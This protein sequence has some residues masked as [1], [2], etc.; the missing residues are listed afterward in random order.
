MSSCI[1]TNCCSQEVTS[2]SITSWTGAGILCPYSVCSRCDVILS[3]PPGAHGRRKRCG[4]WKRVALSVTKTNIH[5]IPPDDA[6]FITWGVKLY[7]SI[8]KYLWYLPIFFP[9]CFH[10]S[11]PQSHIIALN[12]TN[13][14]EGS[15]GG[16]I[17]ILV[18]QVLWKR[19]SI[20]SNLFPGLYFSILF[21]KQIDFFLHFF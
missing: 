7:M 2:N 19:M 18:V 17:S 3:F 20:I 21:F 11:R 6:Y 15:K 14:M 12:Q 13:V 10:Q 8:I 16:K 1:N 5:Q 4:G 9:T